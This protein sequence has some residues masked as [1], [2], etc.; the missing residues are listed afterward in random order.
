M[1]KKGIYLVT[2]PACLEIGS[3][4]HRHIEI[5][6]RMLSNYFD[7]RLIA[8]KAEQSL[9]KTAST[10]AKLDNW[11]KHFLKKIGFWGVVKDV[12]I[13]TKNHFKLFS[14]YKNFKAQHPD[15]IYER[16]SYLNYNGLL[17]S[18]VLNIPHFYESNGIHYYARQSMYKSWFNPIA[19]FLEKNAYEKSDYVFFIGLRGNLVNSKKTNW[20]NIENGI[21]KDFIDH[22]KTHQKEI[23][24]H[25]NICFVGSLMKHHNFPLLIKALHQIKHKSNFHLHLIGSKLETVHLELKDILPTKNHGFLK[26]D[27]LKNLLEKMHV[28]LIPGGPDYSSHMKLFDYGAAKCIVIAPNLKNIVYWFSEDELITFKNNSAQ[29]LVTKL[30]SINRSYIENN[31]LGEN[32][33]LKINN[34]FTWETIFSTKANIIKNVLSGESNPLVHNNY[35]RKVES[36]I[37]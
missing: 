18:K 10:D 6:M 25:I 2:E 1:K 33:H 31:K 15:F 34:N 14:L 32:L 29:D 30:N 7:I 8:P 4:A 16:N 23:N 36:E 12:V 13:L 22:F 21:E 28:G 5:G 37:N 20:S 35:K 17:I 3:G 27:E 9:E 11:V 26:R 19:E 24:R